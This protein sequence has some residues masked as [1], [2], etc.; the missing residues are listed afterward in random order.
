[1]IR[2]FMVI[3]AAM[4]VIGCTQT[5]VTEVDPQP[6]LP[7]SRLGDEVKQI[8]FARSINGWK[9]FNG[10]RHSVILTKGVKDEYKLELSGFCDISRGAS[11]IATRTRGSSCLSRGDEII[12]SDG[13]SGVERCFIKKIYKWQAEMPKETKTEDGDSTTELE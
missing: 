1:M 6:T 7:N 9:E 4:A 11:S 2:N 3:F 8:C 12:V 13:F 5:T 10:E